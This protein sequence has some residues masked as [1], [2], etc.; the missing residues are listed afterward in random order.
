MRSNLDPRRTLNFLDSCAFDPKYSP[1]QESAKKINRLYDEGEVVVHVAHSNQNEVD[2]PNTPDEVKR[3]AASMI[4]SL[5]TS[6]TPPELQRKAAIHAILTGNGNSQKFAAD[7]TH[8]FEADKYQGY[9]IT[10]DER[11]LGK[12]E[13]LGDIC[14]AVIVKPSQWLAIFEHTS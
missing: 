5:E 13:D 12:K 2:H 11:I 6:L 4:F 1:E 10:T 14:N 7:A 3:Q 9:F 8:V